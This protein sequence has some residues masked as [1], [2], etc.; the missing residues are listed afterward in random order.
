[1]YSLGSWYRDSPIFYLLMILYL[2][3][4]AHYRHDLY[5]K[6]E[7]NLFALH[8]FFDVSHWVLKS[9]VPQGDFALFS[10]SFRAEL[11]NDHVVDDIVANAGDVVCVMLVMRI[12]VEE[13]LFDVPV[14]DGAEVCI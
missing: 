6:L 13:Y 2:V 3:D 7:G 1:M 5:P 8:H 12:Y 14:E 11:L 10:P 4:F 9:S